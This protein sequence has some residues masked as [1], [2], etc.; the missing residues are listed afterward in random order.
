MKNKTRITALLTALVMMFTLT[1][2][3]LDMEFMTA[4]WDGYVNG[5]KIWDNPNR[6]E[7]TTV[8]TEDGTLP[9]EGV[10]VEEVSVDEN[11][12]V[13]SDEGGEVQ[14]EIVTETQTNAAGQT[15]IVTKKVTQKVPQTAKPQGGSTQ[16][17]KPQAGGSV[18]TTKA[19]SNGGTVQTT[20]AANKTYTAAEALELY[21]SAANPI[22][23]KSGVTVTRTREV[24]TEVGSS[25]LSGL[26]GTIIK[27]AFGPKDD[28]EQKVFSTPSDI[29]KSFVVE[30][31]SYVC[32]LSMSDV[33]SVTAKQSGNNTVVTIY[34]KDD[35]SNNQ[36]Y[37]NK[38]VSATAVAELAAT[39][40]SGLTMKCK[41][42]R[43]TA[44]IDSQGRLINL[45]TYM[46]AY[47]S[48]DDQYFGAA[49]EQ[50]WTVS[51]K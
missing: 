1:G 19:A 22:K 8:P 49:I 27:K 12:N 25:N 42:V 45:N 32:N 21:K 46:P 43:V 10:S 9:E 31:Q 50:W 23:S 20:Q 48:K 13:I 35:T 5:E 17:T 11:G 4:G 39:F 14:E 2:C 41:D 33:K 44:T 40:S 29:V 18:N 37:S 3:V 30:K 28:K 16:G 7:A 34:V 47:F 6:G 51:Y 36:N 38:A 24:Y 15:V 26:S